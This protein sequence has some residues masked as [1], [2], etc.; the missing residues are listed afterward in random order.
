M[1]TIDLIIILLV[2]GIIACGMMISR[3]VGADEYWTRSARA[4]TTL[5]LVVETENPCGR[6]IDGCALPAEGIIVLRKNMD[7]VLKACVLSHEK[8]HLAGFDH[9]DRIVFATD[10]GD[11]TILSR[12]PRNQ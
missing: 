4:G 12:P 10:C 1:R 3:E 11:G 2:L 6:R 8:K 5:T 9:D 7:A